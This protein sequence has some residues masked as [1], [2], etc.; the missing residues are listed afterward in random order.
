MRPIFPAQP[1]EVRAKEGDEPT[2][3]VLLVDRPFAAEMTAK[4]EPKR[5]GGGGAQYQAS[6]PALA[7][8]GRGLCLRDNG[9][10]SAPIISQL[11]AD[12]NA[13]SEICALYSS[14]AAV[15]HRRVL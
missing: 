4:H 12:E 7:V 14:V 11:P 9:I 6:E 10:Q 1:K 2:V 15:Y 3:V 5:A 13:A 8:R